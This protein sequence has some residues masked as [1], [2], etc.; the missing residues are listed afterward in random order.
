M[1]NFLTRFFTPK[2]KIDPQEKHNKLVEAFALG[3]RAAQEVVALIDK[4]YDRTVVPF[5][6]KMWG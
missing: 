3:H 5:I 6:V 4:F 2:V 1:A